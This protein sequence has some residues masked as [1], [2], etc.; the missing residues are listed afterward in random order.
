MPSLRAALK[1]SAR[2]YSQA[3]EDILVSHLFVELGLRRPSYLDIGAHHPTWLS[4]TFFFYRRRSR[5]VLVDPD[6]S[7]ARRL[8][9]RR[10]RDTFVNAAVAGEDGERTMYM[11][12]GGTFALAHMN[13]LS[14]ESADEFRREGWKPVGT[15]TVPVL[16][17]TTL[18]ERH[19]AGK[20]PDLVSLDIEGVD[21]EVLRAWDFGRFRPRAL[22]VETLTFSDD[23]S[24][25]IKRPE[26]SAVMEE[27][28]YV[29][30]GDTHL[31][32]VFV[33]P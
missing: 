15:M 5:G 28:G 6:P 9:L 1:V 27:A 14:P 2:S 23:G 3:G 4:N 19:C 24:R 17:P 20:A 10:P 26:I 33:D 7:V 13:T 11:F 30:Y 31:N 21:L 32:T 8:K 12:R 29:V 16:S 25:S 22:I 18:M